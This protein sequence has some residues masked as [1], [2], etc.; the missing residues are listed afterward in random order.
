MRDKEI[1]FIIEYADRLAL[2]E[3]KSSQT[4]LKKLADNLNLFEKNA[5]EIK[6]EKTVI[7]D[8]PNNM[9][10]DETFFVNRRSVRY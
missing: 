2:Y 10:L 5:G 1:D 9:S 4:A 8:G 3:I 7:Y 6:C